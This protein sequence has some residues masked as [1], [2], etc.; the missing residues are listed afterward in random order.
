[1]WNKKKEYFQKRYELDMIEKRLCNEDITLNQFRK[2]M[3]IQLV[4]DLELQFLMPQWI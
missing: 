2:E 4:K 3:T 1:M